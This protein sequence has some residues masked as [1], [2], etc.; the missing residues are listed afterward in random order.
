MTYM[1]V[2]NLMTVMTVMTVLTVMKKISPRLTFK[3]LGGIALFNPIYK[4][5]NWFSNAILKFH[6]GTL[7]FYYYFLFLLDPPACWQQKA[8]HS[9]L[10]STSGL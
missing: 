3:V 1:T 8:L 10:Q 5:S 2:M 4:N 7:V 9:R 6:L